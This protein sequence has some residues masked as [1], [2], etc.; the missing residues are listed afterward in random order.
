MTERFLTP[1]DHLGMGSYNIPL[2]TGIRL[3]RGYLISKV[4][5]LQTTDIKTVL[6]VS[7]S[8]TKGKRDT[9]KIQVHPKLK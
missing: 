9:R 6:L 5:A 1:R 7:K 8:T 2:W 3:F 4:L